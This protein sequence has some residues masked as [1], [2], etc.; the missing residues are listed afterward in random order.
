MTR[1]NNKRSNIENAD[2]QIQWL[3]RSILYLI[4]EL[5]NI[6]RRQERIISEQLE[7]WEIVEARARSH[8]RRQYR[9]LSE[10]LGIQESIETR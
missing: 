10:L 3:I 6:S 7:L 5:T 8:S 1:E 9:I 4:I 2:N